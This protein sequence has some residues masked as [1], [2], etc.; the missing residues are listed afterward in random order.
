MFAAGHTPRPFL[1]EA[2]KARAVQAYLSNR[3]LTLGLPKAQ[4]LSYHGRPYLPIDTAVPPPPPKGK[5]YARPFRL[6]AIG[7]SFFEPRSDVSMATLRSRIR[8][9]AKDY[10]PAKFDMAEETQNG[11]PGFRVWRVA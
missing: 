7:D 3:R 6:M 8:W 11:Q 1:T 10:I 5:T 4:Q 2:A 9:D